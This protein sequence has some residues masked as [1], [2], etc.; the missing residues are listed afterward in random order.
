MEN[1]PSIDNVRHKTNLF[2]VMKKGARHHHYLPQIYLKGFINSESKRPKITVID[3][4]KKRYFETS[5]RNIGGKRDFNRIEINGHKPNIIE[6]KLS[7]FENNIRSVINSIET[8]LRIDDNSYN[9]LMNLIALLAIRNPRNRDYVS[10]FHEELLKHMLGIRLATK[11]RW[12]SMKTINEQ[13]TNELEDN[14][15]Y[16]EL[17]SFFDSNQYKITI[18]RE[19][20][21]SIESEQIDAILPYLYN[22]NWLL[23]Q[24]PNKENLFITSDFPV[25]LTWKNP[26]EIP[27]FYRNSPGYGL[28]NTEVTF[29]LTKNYAVI[30]DFENDRKFIQANSELVAA[31][32]SRMLSFTNKQVFS[33]NLNFKYLDK[34]GKLKKGSELLVK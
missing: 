28:K 26:N 18:P 32:N 9:L 22:R 19:Y 21:I 30:G 31:I 13:G 3:L 14:I 25:V 24:A 8:Q 4:K 1:F 17:K 23:I 12:E 5:P 34:R 6:T 16:E 7:H 2:L 33:T 29:P 10:D 15:S 11:E 27:L 20:Q